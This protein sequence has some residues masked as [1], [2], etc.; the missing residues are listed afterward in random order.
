M[1]LRLDSVRRIITKTKLTS[2]SKYV[3]FLH[4]CHGDFDVAFSKY[5]IA[6]QSMPESWALWNN[7]G[8][9]LYGKQKYVSV[10][11]SIC[12]LYRY[13]RCVVALWTYRAHNCLNIVY[14]H[15]IAKTAHHLLHVYMTSCSV[16]SGSILTMI[17]IFKIETKLN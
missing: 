6:S 4:Q 2:S 12:V 11:L 1:N 7:I 14:R 3:L 15:C 8:M 16:M 13:T 9:C 10:S 5:K 17:R